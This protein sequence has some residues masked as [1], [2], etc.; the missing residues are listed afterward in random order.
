MSIF[1]DGIVGA[2]LAPR[3]NVG[4]PPTLPPPL[5]LFLICDIL[6]AAPAIEP[7][8]P[9]PADTVLIVTQG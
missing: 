9:K 1:A 7:A 8:I 6:L 2:E 5:S 4:A 3:G